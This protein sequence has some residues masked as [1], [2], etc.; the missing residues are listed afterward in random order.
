MSP[1]QTATLSWATTDATTVT[2]DQGVGAVGTT[3]SATVSPNA[4]TTYTLTATGAG[5][6]TVASVTVNVASGDVTPPST[7]TNFTAQATSRS[8]VNLSWAASTDDVAVAGYKIYR[9]GQQI[10][11]SPTTA[12]TDTG[13]NSSTTYTYNVAA[14]DAAGNNSAQSQAAVVVTPNNQAPSV[15][16]VSPTNN[17]VF[18]APATIV[19]QAQ[20]NDPDGV[21]AKVEFFQ[22][23]TK[24][25]EDLAVDASGYYSFTWGNVAAGGYALTVVATDDGGA[26]TRSNP[27][28]VTVGSA[29]FSIT[30][31]PSSRT[32]TRGSAVTYTVTV[33]P[34]GGFAG[35]V[36]FSVVGLPGG[37]TAGFAPGS[38]TASGTSTL[39]VGTSSTTPAGRYTL[40]VNGVSGALQ[41]RANV[42][43]TVK[44]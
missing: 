32:V 11:T 18:P 28:S 21:V 2:I 24:L 43:L 29:D 3:G 13:L 27:V 9:D 42:T 12:F 25:G 30:A 31:S 44:K 16:L 22:G 36:N 39:K 14:F 7:P 20:A 41:R 8:Q 35:V 37:A 5:G 6:S 34:S 33:S 40:T 19:L 38:V 26:T 17:A 1:G 10:A 23:S 4:T 15:S